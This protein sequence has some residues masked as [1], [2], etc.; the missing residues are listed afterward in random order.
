MQF[1]AQDTLGNTL[2]Q[3][4][5]GLPRSGE[6]IGAE[7]IGETPMTQRDNCIADTNEEETVNNQV[8]TTE[9]DGEDFGAVVSKR[10]F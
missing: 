5:L 9:D 3:S 10:T 2:S 6:S 8:E 4:A 1:V 7:P